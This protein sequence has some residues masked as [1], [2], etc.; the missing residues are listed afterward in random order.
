MIQTLPLDLVFF[1]FSFFFLNHQRDSLNVLLEIQSLL[2]DWN[3]WR[4]VT[5]LEC[6]ERHV[7]KQAAFL[8]S[9]V[10]KYACR[11]ETRPCNLLFF[12]QICPR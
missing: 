6:S 1:S 2:A 7:R 8:F 9:Q 11:I 12:N 4:Q 3:N 5:D 10:Q